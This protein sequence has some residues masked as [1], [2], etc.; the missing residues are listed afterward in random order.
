MLLLAKHALIPSFLLALSSP[1]DR[2]PTGSS[3]KRDP[4]EECSR[5]FLSDPANYDSARCFL[6][7]PKEIPRSSILK[8]ISN[9]RERHADSLYLALAEQFLLAPSLDYDFRRSSLEKL[10]YRAELDANPRAQ[11]CVLAHM[12]FI[13]S[14]HAKLRDESLDI[15]RLVALAESTKDHIAKVHARSL[16]ADSLNRAEVE[17]RQL[18]QYLAVDQ[19][20]QSTLPYYVVRTLLRVRAESSR[21]T[22]RFHH[23]AND[24]HA[25]AEAAG[26][27]GD[28]ITYSMATL[29]YALVLLEQVSVHQN[30]L[31]IEAAI[32]AFESALQSAERSGAK[33]TRLTALINLTRLYGRRSIDS[34]KQKSTASL[35]ISGARAIGDTY[36]LG[37]CQA[38]R[39]QI[40]STSA[41]ELALE[42]AM[43][44]LEQL[45]QSHYVGARIESWRQIARRLWQLEDE[46]TA[47]T[48]A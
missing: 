33:R 5:V 13:S 40:L 20:I 3:P 26:S 37:L 17:G 9:L 30:K 7:L 1:S 24:F 4:L 27:R 12:L 15:Q 34:A 10:L 21:L 23:A 29:G 36:K 42:S 28:E 6:V 44:S 25:L 16:V 46:D 41:P 38:G 11:A 47:S 39:S 2:T 35:C 43:R 32:G 22:Q 31:G 14:R 19:S 18:T 45:G 8:A 48:F